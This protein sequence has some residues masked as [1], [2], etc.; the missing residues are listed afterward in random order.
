[1]EIA[2]GDCMGIM[3]SQMEHQIEMDW[4]LQYKSPIPPKLKTRN[5][6]P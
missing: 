6:S 2:H 4:K 5:K 3:E 1:M